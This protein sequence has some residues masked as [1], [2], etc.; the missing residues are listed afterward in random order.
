MMMAKF[1]GICS[2]CSQKFP[3]GTEIEYNKE[4]RTATHRACPEPGQPQQKPAAPVAEP[5]AA[6]SLEDRVQLLGKRLS[7]LE[8]VVARMVGSQDERR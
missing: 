1:S 3:A 4:L 8:A 2:R 5:K 6:P 7:A